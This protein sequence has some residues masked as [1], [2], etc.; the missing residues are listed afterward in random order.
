MTQQSSF[1]R[2]GTRP[3]T[4]SRHAADTARL[5]APLAIAQLA[6]MA[7]SVTDTVLL[8]SLGADALAAGGLG[9]ALYFVVVTLLQGVALPVCRAKAVISCGAPGSVVVTRKI[10]PLSSAASA[11]FV[12]RM[13]KGHRKPLASSSASNSIIALQIFLLRTTHRMMPPHT[14]FTFHLPV[15]LGRRC[16]GAFRPTTV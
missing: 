9:A 5:A 8:G 14:F 1:S 7:M 11:F 15:C 10:C 6:Q 3:P 4:L 12:R 13:G 16:A 2:V